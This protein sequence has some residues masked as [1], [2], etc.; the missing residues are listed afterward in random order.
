MLFLSYVQLLCGLAMKQKIICAKCKVEI[1]IKRN[2]DQCYCADPDCQKVRK[3]KWRREKMR[4]DPDYKTNQKVVNKNWQTRN[5]DYWRDYRNSHP[6]YVKANRDKQRIRD[7]SGGVTQSPGII[8]DASRLAKSDALTSG[9]LI[10]S[11]S[12][13]LTPLDAELAKSDAYLVKISL[14]TATYAETANLAKSPL[15]SQ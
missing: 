1:I 4:N 11:G 9:S 3:N 15:Y 14:I 12:Y 7:K 8:S 2:Q 5:P 13:W 6:D 10:E